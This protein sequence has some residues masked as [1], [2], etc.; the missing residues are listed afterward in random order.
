MAGIQLKEGKAPFKVPSID[1]SCFTYYKIIGDLSSGKPPVV[2]A[3]GG[4]GSGHEYLLT[5]AGL[6][7][8]YGLPVV[9]YDQIGCAS[10][11]RLPQKSGDQSFWQEKLFQDELDNLLDHLELR[12]GPGFHLLGQS[13]GGMLAAAFAARQP[14]GLRRLVLASAVASK[15]LGIQAVRLWRDQMPPAMQQALNDA[16]Q[17]G[18]YDSPAYKQALGFYNKK[19]V[20]RAD[21][22]PPT[23]LLPALKHLM[24]DTTVYRTMKAEVQIKEIRQSLFCFAFSTS[25]PVSP[26]HQYLLMLV[27][28]VC[29][30]CTSKSSRNGPSPLTA[31]GSLNEWT[32]I[33]RLPDITAPT[34]IYNGEYDTSHNITQVPF[35]E[36]IP[37]VR[38]ITF[39]NGGHMCHLEGEGL[40][41]GIL[42]AVGEFLTQ[43]DH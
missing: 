19:H 21:P 16:E 13:W 5:F 31:D 41:E 32:V 8:E 4:P 29:L 22:F 12:R 43:G 40:R 37:R 38:W 10:S 9:F 11:T 1:G 42:K 6:W 34:F 7:R 39:P 35:F 26:E 33:S 23:E 20:C 28:R 27:K 36:L 3:H 2:I 25:F 14:Q 24:E 15:E 17:K 18:E 30:D